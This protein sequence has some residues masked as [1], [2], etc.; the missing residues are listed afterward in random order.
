[1]YIV[2]YALYW[3]KIASKSIPR[4]CKQTRVINLALSL[5]GIL[6]ELLLMLYRAH[7]AS[8]TC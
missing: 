6:L 1:M 8:I 2:C 7:F 5:D 4:R 3:C